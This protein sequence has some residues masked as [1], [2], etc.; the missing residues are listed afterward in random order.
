MQFPMYTV[1]VKDVLEMDLLRPHE[2]LLND[3]VLVEFDSS[4][5]K[6]AFISHQWVSASNPDPDL[7]Q[8]KHLQSVLKN[9]LTSSAKRVDPHIM[10]ELLTTF[11]W[12]K[13]IPT[14]EFRSRPLFI[15]YDYFSVPQIDHTKWLIS[16]FHKPID[17]AL[18][19]IPAYIARCEFFFVLA[20]PVENRDQTELLGISTWAS[21][22]WCRFEKALKELAPDNRYIVPRTADVGRLF[23][24]VA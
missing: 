12:V 18:Q 16:D 24:H 2:Q 17:Q 11:G 23:A 13:G 3:D 15:W 21:R 5:G 14:A 4:M 7:W 8:F 9:I 6:A 19:S 22:G 20:P 10:T 1:P